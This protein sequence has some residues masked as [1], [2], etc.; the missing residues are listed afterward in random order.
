MPGKWDVDSIAWEFA[1]PR[2]QRWAIARMLRN[3]QFPDNKHLAQIYRPLERWTEWYFRYRDSNH[4]GLPEYRHG[5]ESGWDNSTVFNDGTPLESP[6]LSALLSVQ[7][8]TLAKI[9]TRLGKPTEAKAW[10]QRSDELLARMLDH[11]WRDGEFVA[12][13]VADEHPIHS[14]SSGLSMPIILGPHLPVAVPI[15]LRQAIQH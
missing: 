15:N 12:I 9:A 7:M 11:F 1:R 5:N 14:R 3:G 10:N 8:Q 2:R 4:D 6:D 13:R